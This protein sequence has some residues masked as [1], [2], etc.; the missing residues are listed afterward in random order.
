MKKLPMMSTMVV[1]VLGL[2][3]AAFASG[4]WSGAE[5]KYEEFKREQ[6]DFKKLQ[7]GETRKIVT[8]ICEAEEADRKSAASEAKSRVESTI[9]DKNSRLRSLRDEA[10]R[11]LREV[12]ADESLKDYH[13]KAKEYEEDVN[14]RWGSAQ[15]LKGVNH[16]VTAYMVEQGQKEH[17]NYQKNS[18]YCHVYEFAM[19]S[20]RADCLI[21]AGSTCYVVELKPDNS[22]AISRGRGQAADYAEELNKNSDTQ[23]KLINKDSRFSACT[24]YEARVDC[25]KLCPEIDD[26]NNM[27][28]TYPVWRSRC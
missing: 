18:S 16:P 1:S 24:R 7:P 19:N 12:Q 9:N 23:K 15:S 13:G 28:S 21:A 2:V 5:R 3:A 6:E 26:D 11:M 20:G 27:K 10:E 25:Y 4:D 14:R 22:R 8:A 17:E